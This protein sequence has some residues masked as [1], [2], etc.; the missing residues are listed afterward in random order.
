MTDLYA[1]VIEKW[2]A[3]MSN[4]HLENLKLEYFLNKNWTGMLKRFKQQI[5]YLIF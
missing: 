1:L 5:K 3:N 2:K 4:S